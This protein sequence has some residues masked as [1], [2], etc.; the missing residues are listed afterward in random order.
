MKPIDD[1]LIDTRTLF[2][3]CGGDPV[4]L[5][6]MIHSFQTHFEGR[7]NDLVNAVKHQDGAS[8]RA[9]THKLHGLVS[10]FSRRADE[11]VTILEQLGNDG[12]WNDADRQSVAVDE[13][14]HSLATSLDRVTVEELNRDAGG[15]LQQ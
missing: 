6:T 14:L 9:A 2:V 4:L 1:P 13:L 15:P 3:T 5:Q 8:L 12:H 7:L 11:A 10:A